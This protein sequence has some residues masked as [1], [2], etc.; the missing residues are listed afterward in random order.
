MTNIS[1]APDTF[2]EDI[3]VDPVLFGLKNDIINHPRKHTL[4]DFSKHFGYTKPTFEL[5]DGWQWAKDQIDSLKR[6]YKPYLPKFFRRADQKQRVLGDFRHPAP[7]DKAL[8]YRFID[9]Q[10]KHGAVKICDADCDFEWSQEWEDKA[11]PTII[12]RTFPSPNFHAQWFCQDY[13]SRS[14]RHLVQYYFK[15]RFHVDVA[16][17]GNLL[18]SPCLN[19]PRRKNL[20]LRNK[21]NK[22]EPWADECIIRIPSDAKVY[23]KA[24]LFALLGVKTKQVVV[25]DKVVT[26]PVTPVAKIMSMNINNPFLDGFLDELVSLSPRQKAIAILNYQ[27]SV[28][29]GQRFHNMRDVTCRL[30]YRLFHTNE[31]CLDNVIAIARNNSSGLTGGEVKSLAQWVFNRV[32]RMKWVKNGEKPHDVN[33]R[34]R[35]AREEGQLQTDYARETF[36]P[37]SKV[38]YMVRKNQLVSYLS[39]W[40]K[41]DEYENTIIAE[42]I[43]SSTVAPNKFELKEHE[44]STP[45]TSRIDTLYPYTYPSLPKQAEDEDGDL[46]KDL[47]LMEVEIPPPIP[48]PKVLTTLSAIDL[49]KLWD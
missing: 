49:S 35:I 9:P 39:R 12:V 5:P 6:L 28:E 44:L 31:W 17:S 48:P 19:K 45:D 27:S 18:M 29:E 20:E 40:M 22:I 43:V 15:M 2:F 1:D 14:E 38:Y 41:K 21:D 23:S 33:V 42:D 47:N 3:K 32:E 30:A 7:T 24:E 10:F 11:K 8:S 46:F 37:L 16:S 13:L 25:N 36:T 34:W 26:K 4:E